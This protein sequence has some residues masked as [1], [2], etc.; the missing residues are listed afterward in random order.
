MEEDQKGSVLNQKRKNAEIEQDTKSFV[1][2]EENKRKVSEA[3]T[4]AMGA[5]LKYEAELSYTVKKNEAH[6]KYLNN[7]K[8][9][10]G[11][12]FNTERFAQAITEGANAFTVFGENEINVHTHN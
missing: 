1:Q 4:E 7:T 5:T 11:D 10:L 3:E 9:I 8:I 12:S 6:E 2:Q